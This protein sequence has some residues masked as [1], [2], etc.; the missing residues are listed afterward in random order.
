M[1][2]VS[3]WES[4]AARKADLT[5]TCPLQSP[6]RFPACARGPSTVPLPPRSAGPSMRCVSTAEVHCYV[7]RIVS[8]ADGLAVECACALGYPRRARTSRVEQNAVRRRWTCVVGFAF[9]LVLLDAGGHR[10]H[11]CMHLLQQLPTHRCQTTSLLQSHLPS[12]SLFEHKHAD[13]PPAWRRPRV[14]RI[15]TSGR[16]VMRARPAACSCTSS[17]SR[18][19]SMLSQLHPAPPLSA[20]LFA[21]LLSTTSSVVPRPFTSHSLRSGA[22]F[23]ASV[24]HRH[25]TWLD[26]G[27]NT[28]YSYCKCT[29]MNR[30]RGTRKYQ[31]KGGGDTRDA[32]ARNVFSD[33][34]MHL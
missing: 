18:A 31:G 13:M 12:P 14:A 25:A 29:A 2:G 33:D 8:A 32:E 34:E 20:L 17:C 21:S 15:G 27:W 9:Y 28:S 11:H 23:S 30:L 10:R 6:G 4:D 7:S 3:L 1:L 22:A 26:T 24:G 5:C 16:G 19:R